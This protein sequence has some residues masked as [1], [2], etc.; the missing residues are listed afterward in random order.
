MKARKLKR[1]ALAAALAGT[2]LAGVPQTTF[3]QQTASDLLGILSAQVQANN[4]AAAR[5]TI[6]EM[7]ALGIG[8]ISVGSDT[9]TL[10]ELEGMIASAEAGT[11]D[12]GALASYLDS[13]ASS[14][15]QALFAPSPSVTDNPTVNDNEADEP[16]PFPVGSSG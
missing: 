9:I 15:A 3:A 1:I 10:A 12:P 5:S 13:L 4:F 16:N 7:Q 2:M 8:S 11:T 14:A 6:A